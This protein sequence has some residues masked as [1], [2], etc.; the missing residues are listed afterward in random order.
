MKDEWAMGACR[1]VCVLKEISGGWAVMHSEWGAGGSS[2]ELT[3]ET[4][5]C[6]DRAGQVKI[7]GER[8]R[9]GGWHMQRNSRGCCPRSAE[10][11]ERGG[12]RVARTTERSLDFMLRR[13]VYC[14]LPLKNI[15]WGVPK[16]ERNV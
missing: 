12:V 6:D 4:D 10:S 7:R 5:L 9:P 1:Q 15:S 11:R 16:G 14:P 13:K 8:S 3:F 2:G